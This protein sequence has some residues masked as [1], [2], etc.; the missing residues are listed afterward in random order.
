MRVTI[1]GLT[2]STI[3]FNTLGIVLRGNIEARSIDLK[4]DAQIREVNSL[5]NAGLIE[6]IRE[7]PVI[8]SNP[9]IVPKT[10]PVIPSPTTTPNPTPVEDKPKTFKGGRPKGSKNKAKPAKKPIKTAVT[11][12]KKLAPV[13]VSSGSN[14]EEME[15]KVVVMTSGGPVDG[16]MVKSVTGDMPD[17]DATQASLQALKD[18]EAEEKADREREEVVEDQSKLDASE[19]TGGEAVVATGDRKATK[20]AMKNSILPEAEAI[21]KAEKFIPLDQSEDKSADAFLD[22]EENEEGDDDLE[23]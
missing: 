18:I 6:I 2:A 10:Q 17:S 3:S 5:S 8:I 19:K 1:K 4:N 12:I 11:P 14:P 7:E 9:I 16:H 15:G 21:K 22:E 20:I 13:K 23:I